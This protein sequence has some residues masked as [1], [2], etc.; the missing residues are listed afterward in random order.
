[1]LYFADAEISER[2]IHLTLSS[3]GHPHTELQGSSEI[4]KPRVF[5]HRD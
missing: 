2:P 5:R 3:K 4:A 1:M